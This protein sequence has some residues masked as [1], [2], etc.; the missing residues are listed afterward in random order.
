VFRVG[1]AG[2]GILGACLGK[3]E[4]AWRAAGLYRGELAIPD[5]TGVRWT[6]VADLEG[7]HAEAW[8][9]YRLP[10]I[11]QAYRDNQPLPPIEVWVRRDGRV[12]LADGNH[13]LVA[14]RDMGISAIRVRWGWDRG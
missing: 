8:A 11:R 12:V 2:D 10:S 5:R 9:P 14:A 7:I 4:E 3:H 13:R 6:K 1:S